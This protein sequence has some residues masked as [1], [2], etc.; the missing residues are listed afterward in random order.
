MHPVEGEK[1]LNDYFKVARKFVSLYYRVLNNYE[2]Y[3]FRFYGS[4]SSVVVCEVPEVGAQKTTKAEGADMVHKLLS[5]LYA[6]V[7]VTV[8]TCTPQP[9]TG[10]CLSLLVTGTMSRRHFSEEVSFTQALILSRQRDGYYIKTDTV[11]VF[12]QT[13]PCP[14]KTRF[15][16]SVFPSMVAY[17]SN[18]DVVKASTK[19][20]DTSVNAQFSNDKDYSRRNALVSANTANISN[21]GVYR[22]NIKQTNYKES[23]ESLTTVV[24]LKRPED[25][26]C[27][28]TI[29]I[30]STTQ[31]PSSMNMKENGTGAATMCVK[32][33][34][35]SPYSAP[36]TIFAQNVSS[37]KQ[38]AGNS[39]FP[40]PRNCVAEVIPQ[41]PPTQLRSL[42][43]CKLPL[44][45]TVEEVTELFSQFGTLDDD[46]PVKVFT[47]PTNCYAYVNFANEES[48]QNA[49]KG[50][51]FIRDTEIVKEEWRPRQRTH[52]GR[53]R[54]PRK[55][56]TRSSN[57]VTES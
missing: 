26:L 39:Q 47:G 55:T 4:D 10:G 24:G 14:G 33:G 16:E 52:N 6:D 34:S 1:L 21:T 53:T 20:L 22:E 31:L 41:N 12:P 50:E 7:A 11:L 57:A 28:L 46:T 27:N 19:K 40:S 36:T 56:G 32:E 35:G 2:G 42:F 18:E 8:R 45:V 51:T 17:D 43:A 38:E 48:M 23:V 29:P 13:S 5:T 49:L 3:L 54:R 25:A 37:M 9:S 30:T 15:L 44:D